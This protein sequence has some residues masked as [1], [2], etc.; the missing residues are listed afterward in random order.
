MFK[1]LHSFFTKKPIEP[2]DPQMMLSFHAHGGYSANLDVMAW[3]LGWKVAKSSSEESPNKDF[4][5][6]YYES[7]PFPFDEKTFKLA[8]NISKIYYFQKQPKI[9]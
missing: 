5:Y 4:Q 7:S 9:I 6:L 3:Q 2:H 1:F 8:W